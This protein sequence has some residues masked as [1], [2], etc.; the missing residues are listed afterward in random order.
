[1]Y[2]E[3]NR[4]YKN[5]IISKNDLLKKIGDFPRK[6]KGCNVSWCI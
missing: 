1:M 5:K 6:K 2:I 4:K 3:L